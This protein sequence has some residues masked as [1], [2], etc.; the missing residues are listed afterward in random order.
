MNSI[1]LPSWQHAIVGSFLLGRVTGIAV[2]D[3]LDESA[4]VS[5]TTIGQRGVGYPIYL[6]G[7]HTSVA[8]YAV[9]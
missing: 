8:V 3:T 4:C 6:L 5:R 9:I 2:T 1:S 7:I